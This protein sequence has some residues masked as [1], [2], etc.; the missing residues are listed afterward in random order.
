MKNTLTL[1]IGVALIMFVVSCSST[2]FLM[3]KAKVNMYHTAYPQKNENATI[4][5]YRSKKPDKEYIEFAEI[6][7]GDTNDDWSLKQ[8]LIKAR[9][10]GADGIIIIGESGSYGVGVPIGN[11]A[12][13]ASEGY[14]INAIAIKYVSES[15]S[16][17]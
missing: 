14:G 15:R 16:E 5:I 13:Y 2:G 12:Y 6:S 4:D 17:F 9:E 8:I 1:L 11:T 7:C 10:I 3:A